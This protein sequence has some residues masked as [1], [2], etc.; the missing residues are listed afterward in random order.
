[1]TGKD[2]GVIG[3]QGL[4]ISDASVTDGYSHGA[5]MTNVYMIGYAVAEA[6]YTTPVLH[7]GAPQ[8]QYL[9]RASSLGF[10][11]AALILI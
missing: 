1:M 3:T 8:H 2:F 11:I 9:I 5:P 6:V 7:S 4:Y 10:G